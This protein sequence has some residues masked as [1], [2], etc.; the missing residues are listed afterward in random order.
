MP[1]KR[2]TVLQMTDA[3]LNDWIASTIMGYKKIFKENKSGKSF[4]FWKKPSNI[5]GEAV[6]VETSFSPC[7]DLNDIHLMEKRIKALSINGG[8]MRMYLKKLRNKVGKKIFKG[9][10]LVFEFVCAPAR[11][12]AEAAYAIFKNKNYED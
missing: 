12:R 9:D 6:Y 10:N 7:F 3:E 4:S 1:K 5:H 11:L 2:K 8:Y